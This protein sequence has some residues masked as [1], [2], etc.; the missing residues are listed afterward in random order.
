LD[1]AFWHCTLGSYP[2][3]RIFLTVSDGKTV[4]NTVHDGIGHGNVKPHY[5]ALG[6]LGRLVGIWG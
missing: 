5:L 4:V 6:S 3:S 2:N 1:Y